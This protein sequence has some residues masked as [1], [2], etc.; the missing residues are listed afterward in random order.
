[1]GLLPG[2]RLVAGVVFD[3]RG[4]LARLHRI[5]EP[6]PQFVDQAGLLGEDLSGLGEHIG[7][8]FVQLAHAGMEKAD[9]LGVDARAL[10][11]LQRDIGAD[12][13]ADLFRQPVAD[14]DSVG[15]AIK[16]GE[17]G[18]AH[19]LRQLGHF[20]SRRGSMPITVVATSWLA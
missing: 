10:A 11:G 19:L 7:C 1:M 13:G 18:A 6:N 17:R 2:D 3:P 15:G 16:G 20:A 5:G 12:A 4:D 8:A 9:H 14:D